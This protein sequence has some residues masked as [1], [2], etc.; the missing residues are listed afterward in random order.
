MQERIK[1]INKKIKELKEKKKNVKGTECE[2]YARI[3]GYFRAVD[4][5]NKGKRE[6]YTDRKEFKIKRNKK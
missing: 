5:W 1:E 6:E 2:T 4:S 3:V